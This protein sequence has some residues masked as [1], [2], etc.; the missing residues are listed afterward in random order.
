[1]VAAVRRDLERE[2][3]GVGTGVVELSHFQIDEERERNHKRFAFIRNWKLL[4]VC[5]WNGNYR[6]DRCPRKRA[7]PTTDVPHLTSLLLMAMV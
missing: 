7:P 6:N 3:M 2:Q 4:F 5:K 1:M